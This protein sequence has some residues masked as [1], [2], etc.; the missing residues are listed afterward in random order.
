MLLYYDQSGYRVPWNSDDLAGNRL[1]A[2]SLLAEQLLAV[3]CGG[4]SLLCCHM[5][6]DGLVPLVIIIPL[7]LFLFACHRSWSRLKIHLKE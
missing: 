1:L 6:A 2:V 5:P 4:D 3:N 7:V